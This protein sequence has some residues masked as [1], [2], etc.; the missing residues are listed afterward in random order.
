M[1]KLKRTS[2]AKPTPLLKKNLRGQITAL[3]E[4]FELLDEERAQRRPPLDRKIFQHPLVIDRILENQHKKC[5]YCEQ[6]LPNNKLINVSHYRPLSNAI[7]SDQ[8]RSIIDY[9]A[10]FAYEWQNMLIVCKECNIAMREIFPLDGHPVKPMSTWQEAELREKPLLINPY[11]TNPSRHIMFTYEGEAVGRSNQ[12]STTIKIL[13][14]NRSNL[15]LA[16]GKCFEELKDAL[17]ENTSDNLEMRLNTYLSDTIE[18]SGAAVIFL[19]NLYR[20]ADG[21]SSNTEELFGDD[22]INHVA[23]ILSGMPR[24]QVESLFKRLNKRDLGFITYNTILDGFK[25]PLRANNNYITDIS[26]KNFKD[27]SNLSLSLTYNRDIT[28]CVMLLGENS[29]GKS[30]VLQAVKLAL[31]STKEHTYLKAYSSKF[32]SK[33]IPTEIKITFSN[34]EQLILTS[35]SRKLFE[36]SSSV[37]FL[38]FGYGARRYFSTHPGVANKKYFNTTL[39]DPLAMLRDPRDWLADQKDHVFHAIVRAL[40]SI[41]SLRDDESIIKTNQRE[42]LIKA[43]NKLTPVEQLSDGYKSLFIMSIDI[44]RELLNHWDN[45]EVAEAIVLIDEVENHLH[46]RWKMRVMAAL[47]EA[48]PRVQFICTTHDPLCLR[49]MKNGEVRLL[50]RDSNHEIQIYSD[51]P[52]ITTLRIEQILSSDYFGLSSTEDPEQD[53]IIRRLA[54][55]SGIDEHR[56]SKIERDERDTLL[57]QYEGIPYI[58]SSLD[59]Q[60]LAEALTRHLRLHPEVGIIDRGLARE[61]SIEAIM[62]VLRRA[63]DK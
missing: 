40:R 32:I 61:Q 18:Y 58:G 46:P 59:R 25:L 16:R 11:T 34:H 12:G 50:Q 7:F 44:M 2:K 8:G 3:E 37:N 60:I 33:K 19:Q 15:V 42:L 48:M 20:V 35:N 39:F 10:W 9:Y 41:L 29:T 62:G 49:G 4:Y 22:L 17:L 52:D 30:S 23:N 45:L 13:D 38:V 28:P 6:Y 57:E 5:A 14:L 53:Y 43:H 36:V 54:E 27:L 51:L 47:R 55:L 26:I 63:M 21:T 56:L 1:R 24:S 31:S